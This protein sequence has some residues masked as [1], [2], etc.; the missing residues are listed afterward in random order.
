MAKAPLTGGKRFVSLNK[1]CSASLK[2]FCKQSQH[3]LNALALAELFP[4][5]SAKQTALTFHLKAETRARQDYE[6]RRRDLL[7]FLEK[8]VRTPEKKK[9]RR[10]RRPDKR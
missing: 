6:R 10:I 8:K 4:N 1:A 2:V 3:T 5:D 7:E 9:A